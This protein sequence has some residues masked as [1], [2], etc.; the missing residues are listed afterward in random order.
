MGLKLTRVSS[1]AF[2]KTLKRVNSFPA[3]VIKQLK[4]DARKAVALIKKDAP[5]DTG[6]LRRNVKV[7]VENGNQ[8]YIISEAKDPRTGRDYAPVQEY[9]LEG[10]TPQPFFRKNIDIVF[11]GL[12]ARLRRKLNKKINNKI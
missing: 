3:D 10:L 5:Y 7:E 11:N 2:N 1:V 12:F 4:E 8:I 9:G 6:R